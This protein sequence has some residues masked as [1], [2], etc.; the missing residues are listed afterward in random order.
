MLVFNIDVDVR[1]EIELCGKGDV[2]QG[3]VVDVKYVVE[4]EVMC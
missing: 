4:V 1:Y 3:Y 2:K